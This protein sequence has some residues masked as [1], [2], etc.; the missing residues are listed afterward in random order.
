MA[1]YHAHLPVS[2]TMYMLSLFG[3]GAF[4]MRGAGCTINDMW[5]RKIDSKVERTANR[6]LASG[7]MT[8]FRALS[9]LG[10]QLSAGLAILT[11]LNWYR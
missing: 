6:P 4:I 1:T 9:F 7:S 3:V 8:P 2:Q 5:D 10:L 11:Q